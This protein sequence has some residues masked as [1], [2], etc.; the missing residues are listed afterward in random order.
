MSQGAEKKSIQVKIFGTDYSLKS[1]RDSEYVESIA[2]Y[3]DEKIQKLSRSTNVNSQTKIAV[4]AALNIAEELFRLKRDQH[5]LREKSIEHEQK[6]K[7]LYDRLEH[8]LND[9]LGVEE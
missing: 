9:I 7:A 1:D 6:S 8:G 4:L 5:L 3:V 2:R